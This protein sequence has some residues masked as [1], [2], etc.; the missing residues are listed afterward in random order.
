M[1]FEVQFL[2]LAAQVEADEVTQVF[3]GKLALDLELERKRTVAVGTGLLPHLHHHFTG[4]RLGEDQLPSNGEVI[5]SLRQGVGGIGLV[6]SQ[7]AGFPDPSDLQV[8]MIAFTTS[9]IHDPEVG[10]IEGQVPSDQREHTTKHNGFQGDPLGISQRAASE[11]LG[12]GWSV[13]APHKTNGPVL[14]RLGDR[15][16]RM[17]AH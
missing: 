5:V 1:L 11:L 13:C 12:I 17:G 3:E 8:Q 10:L 7:G 9:G 2:A 4:F 6:W 16:N 15:G 14:Q